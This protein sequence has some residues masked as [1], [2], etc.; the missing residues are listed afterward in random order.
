MRQHLPRLCLALLLAL[1]L[2]A[3]AADKLAQARSAQEAGRHAEAIALLTPLADAGDAEAKMR[4]GMMHYHGHGVPENEKRGVELLTQSAAL[5]NV[6]AMYQLGSAYTF[7]STTQSLVA[8]AD[9][10]AAKWYF[11]AASKG[12]AEAQYSLG[13]L[14]LVGKGVQRELNEANQWMA[15]AA[16]AGHPDA[17]KYMSGVDK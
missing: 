17:K 16:K 3:S 13:L 4:L 14:F 8:D 15:R 9:V 1:T 7:G 12:H 2:P 10:E 5:G 6:E 11:N